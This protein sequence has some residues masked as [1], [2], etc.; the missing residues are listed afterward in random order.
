MTER[1]MVL[2]AVLHVTVSSP[3]SDR[4]ASARGAPRRRQSLPRGPGGQCEVAPALTDRTPRF[5][6]EIC[7]CRGSPVGPVV[8]LVSICTPRMSPV[9]L[10][11]ERWYG[12]LSA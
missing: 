7:P 3:L 1:L 5:V 2:L 9:S 6:S 4:P 11:G 8:A 10:T 12:V